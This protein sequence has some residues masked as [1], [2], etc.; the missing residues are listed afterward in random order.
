MLGYELCELLRE[1]RYIIS[2]YELEKSRNQVITTSFLKYSTHTH[3]C[4]VNSK[5]SMIESQHASLFVIE[6]SPPI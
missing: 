3:T 6:G 5:V 2:M 1:N 4:V